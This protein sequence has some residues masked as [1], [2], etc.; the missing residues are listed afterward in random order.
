MLSFDLLATD[1]ASHARR[2]A[3]ASV[4]GFAVV[5]LAYLLLRAGENPGAGFL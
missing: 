1:P 2:G 3:L 5:V 4:V